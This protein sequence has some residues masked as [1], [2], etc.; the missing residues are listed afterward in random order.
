MADTPDDPQKPFTDGIHARSGQSFFSPNDTR[1]LGWIREAITEGDR[2]I[3]DDPQFPLIDKAMD[4]VL[5][6]Q[7]G[8]VRPSYLPN[9][10]VNQVKKAVRGHVAALTDIRPLFGFKVF[11][12]R[13]QDQANLLNNLFLMWWINSA[14]DMQLADAL[15]YAL[16]AGAGDMLIEYDPDF[17]E[18]GDNRLVPRDPRDTLP[19]RPTRDFSLQ[20]WEGVI[21]R[22][23]VSINRLR[24][25][26]PERAEKIRIDSQ[27]KWGE[28][29]TKFRRFVSTVVSPTSTLDGLVGGKQRRNSGIPETMLFRVYLDDR[30]L[31]QSG[32]EVLMGTPGTN[33]SYMVPPGSR[34][35]PRKRLIVCT[36]DMILYDGP[37]KYWHGKYPLVR[38][39]L[40]TYPWQFLGLGLVNDLMPLQDALNTIV[41]DFIMTFSQWVNRG[42]VADKNAM[43]ESLF[44]RID[45]RRPNWK[46]KVNPAMGEAFKLMDGPQLP[47]W[48]MEFAKAMFAK[49]DELAETAN[50]QSL[51]QLRQMPGADTIEKYYESLTPGLNLEGRRVEIALREMA[52]MLKVNIFQFYSKARRMLMLGGD[53]QQLEDLD[54]DP[55][56]LVPALAQNDPNYTP[57]LDANLPRERRAQFFHKMFA[58]YVKPRSILGMHAQEEQMK[59]VQLSRQGYMDFWTL[60]DKLEV[61]NAGQPP[62][63]PLPVPNWPPQDPVTGK[64]VYPKDPQT[65]LPLPP[66]LIIRQPENIGERLM[67]QQQMGIGQV[68]NPAGRKASGQEP[69]SLQMGSD[70]S[71]TITE[72]K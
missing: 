47:P 14:A 37:N 48:S 45:P 38:M 30:S 21:L 36:E 34:L 52:G 43:P 6:Q 53:G 61:P 69:P 7:L 49:F 32:K 54:F 29:F 59:Y 9:V 50:L 42:M 16:V 25:A 65:G 62:A 28:V 27:G 41:N 26:Y 44:K 55:D 1:I 3:R 31:N 18:V 15:T 46:A 20:S 22:E 4:Y 66:P 70:G 63:M 11:N 5:G 23:L 8:G 33:W 51:M 67:V 19:F 35:Y 60:M 39:R 56:T 40:D 13:Y 17:D 68:A 71:P 72:S 64:V 58:F 2:F 10:V 57:E 12:E 24:G